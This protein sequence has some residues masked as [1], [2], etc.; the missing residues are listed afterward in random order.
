MVLL[1]VVLAVAV[2]PPAPAAPLD[3]DTARGIAQRGEIRA[4]RAWGEQPGSVVAVRLLGR[5]TARVTIKFVFAW[6]DELDA[7]GEVLTSTPIYARRRV[8]VLPRGAGTGSAIRSW[9]PPA[10]VPAPLPH[11]QDNAVTRGP[12]YVCEGRQM[13]NFQAWEPTEEEIASML[14]SAKPS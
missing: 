2:A 4:A 11:D 14:G 7:A 8:T 10:A 6:F 13:A 9:T 3:R 1:A 12:R 5:R